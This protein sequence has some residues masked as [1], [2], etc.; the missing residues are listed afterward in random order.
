MEIS[1]KVI[2]GNNID[3]CIN[4]GSTIQKLII[5]G[6]NNDIT[7][8]INCIVK[9]NIILNGNN[10]G[11]TFKSDTI[12]NGEIIDNGNGNDVHGGNNN[13]SVIKNSG[14][15]MHIYGGGSITVGNACVVSGNRVTSSG[16]STVIINGKVI[17][18]EVIVNGKRINYA[19]NNID[20]NNGCFNSLQSLL[21][22]N[23]DIM[24]EI[25]D[26]REE[27]RDLKEEITD[28][29]DREEKQDIKE[30]IRDNKQ[31][32]KGL[33]AELKNNLKLAKALSK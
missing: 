16:R 33:K 26:L 11:I 1:S 5:N 31:E 19:N 32:I 3:M 18:D 6:N 29:D 4:N 2:N 7:F 9:G 22:R 10:N 21:E 8:G 13:D 23:R 20:N 25:A 17:K 15:D 30:E 12:V 14:T 28:A 27:I 24:E